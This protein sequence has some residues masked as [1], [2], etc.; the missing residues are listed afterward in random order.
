MGDTAALACKA[1]GKAPFMNPDGLQRCLFYAEQNYCFC[2][3]RPIQQAL[4]G[5]G[6]EVAWLAVGSGID[7]SAFET[8][9]KIF[10][11]VRDAIEWNPRAVM[12]PGNFVPGFLPGIKVMVT[13][14]LISGKRRKK[15]GLVYSFIDRGLFDLYIT[16]GPNTTEKWLDLAMA[17]TF[18]PEDA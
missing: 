8:G 17:D 14:G 16:H 9:E 12:A 3:L 4:R 10:S 1:A 11:H 5:R 13:H 15:D 6:C 18:S 2:I 7:R